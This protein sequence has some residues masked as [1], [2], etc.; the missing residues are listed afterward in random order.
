MKYLLSALILLNIADALL[1]NHIIKLGAGT[2]GNPFLLGIAGEPF[3]T[4][5]K[6][7]GVLLCVLILWDVHRRYPRL[8]L[9][10]TSVFVAAYAVIVFWN[11]RVLS[12]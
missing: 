2:E 12:G 8:A 3:F 9:V 1:T 6:I 4:I 5:I 7:V 11:L 10:S